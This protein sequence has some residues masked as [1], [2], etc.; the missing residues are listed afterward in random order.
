MSLPIE[1]LPMHNVSLTEIEVKLDVPKGYCDGFYRSNKEP[2]MHNVSFPNDLNKHK[3]IIDIPKVYYDKNDEIYYSNKLKKLEIQNLKLKQID[4]IVKRSEREHF[5]INKFEN[6]LK[7][8][9][10]QILKR[11]K[12]LCCSFL[13]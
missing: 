7:R 6:S 1:E 10:P 3:V 12:Y 13:F 4:E 11:R 8:D 5:D 9:G 2:P